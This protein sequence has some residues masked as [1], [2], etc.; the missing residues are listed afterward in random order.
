MP[1]K[2][3]TK[4]E[5]AKHTAAAYKSTPVKQDVTTTNKYDKSTTKSLADAVP[6]LSR[7]KFADFYFR[8]M[9][10]LNY[11]DITE[12]WLD[13]PAW[14]PPPLQRW[15]T[16]KYDYEDII[17]PPQKNINI[18][19]AA[20]TC[21]VPDTLT[22]LIRNTSFGEL[23]TAWQNIM[24]Y[25]R[26]NTRAERR[27]RKAN[28]WRMRMK[29]GEP[30]AIFHEK[31][32]REAN[33]I[34]AM[35]NQ[36]VISNNDMTD[37][38]IEGVLAEHKSEF[39][40]IVTIVDEEGGDLTFDETVQRL[41][42]I[43]TTL[44]LQQARQPIK[45]G[46]NVNAAEDRWA[47]KGLHKPA[48]NTCWRWEK[49]GAC[50]YQGCRYQHDPKTKGVGRITK[51]PASRGNGHH[52]LR[53][54]PAKTYCK[55][56]YKRS[57]RIFTNHSDSDCGFRDRVPGA[58]PNKAHN[59]T[60]E[61]QSAAL[62]EMQKDLA[63][64]KSKLLE[65]A[66]AKESANLGL[67]T[68]DDDGADDEDAEF[69]NFCGDAPEKSHEHVGVTATRHTSMD[70]TAST[71]CEGITETLPYAGLF[72]FVDDDCVPLDCDL[73]NE[74]TCRGVNAD[75]PRTP[76]QPEGH[77]AGDVPY[78]RRGAEMEMR[79]NR[80]SQFFTLLA[81]IMSYGGHFAGEILRRIWNIPRNLI[82]GNFRSDWRI[83]SFTLLCIALCVTAEPASD[84]NITSQVLTPHTIH[85]IPPPPEHHR[86]PNMY[87]HTSPLHR[88]TKHYSLTFRTRMAT[89]NPTNNNW[90]VDSG[91]TTHICTDASAFIPGTLEA[92]SVEITLADGGSI[93]AT[94][95]GTVKLASYIG[96]EMRMTTLHDVLLV[97]TA[98]Y[99]L[100][101]VPKLDDAGY[102][103][104]M[105][106]GTVRIGTGGKAYLF[107]DKHRGRRLYMLD[108]HTNTVQS[109]SANSAFIANSYTTGLN[110]FD[111]WHRRLGHCSERYIKK[112]C[113]KIP[114][115]QKLSFC[116]A[117]KTA[118]LKKQPFTKRPNPY[119]TE[120]MENLDKVVSD[121]SGK[122]PT[123]AL[124]THKRYFGLIV[125][126][127]SR[128]TWV[129]TLRNKSDFM[130]E[131]QDWV[132]YV[133]NQTGKY[134]KVFHT[135]GGG[136]F[137]N[138]ELETYCKQLGIEF[139][140]TTPHNP[141]QNAYAERKIG[142]IKNSAK[143][144]MAQAG[145]TPGYWE[146]A[147]K[148]AVHIA[149]RTPHKHLKYKTP[150]ELWT[151]KKADPR[152][153]QHLRAFGCEA[154]TH[155]PEANRKSMGDKGRKGVFV[156]MGDKEQGYLVY[157]FHTRRV[158]TSR[159]V[160]FNETCFPLAEAAK[161]AEL[162][163][164]EKSNSTNSTK[165]TSTTSASPSSAEP[166]ATAQRTSARG[167]VPSGQALRNL[168]N[169]LDAELEDINT[170]DI[171]MVHAAVT[172]SGVPQTRKAAMASK[173]A[174]EWK[175]AE[176]TELNAL[177]ENNTWN[178][179][180]LPKGV[181]PISCRWVYDLKRNEDN[182]IARYK[183]RLVAKGFQQVEGVNY[184]ETFA[185]VAQMKSFRVIMALATTLNLK[186][187]QLDVKNAFLNGDLEEDIYMQPPPGIILPEGKILKLQKSLYGLK[188][189]GRT[190]SLAL[191]DAL[192][193][194]GFKQLYSDA[195][196][197]THPD[198]Q[199]ILS[200]H[201]DDILIATNDERMRTHVITAL[202]KHF[203][204]KDEGNCSFYLGMH[205]SRKTNTTTIHQ[206]AYISRMVESFRMT[207]AT[208]APTPADCNIVHSKLNCRDST[209]TNT[210]QAQFS[211]IPYRSLIGALLYAG[212]GTR[213]D[214]SQ[215]V[216]TLA[217]FCANFG[218]T[219]WTAAKRI[220]RYLKGTLQR[221]IT[222]Y[223]EG[224]VCIRAFS[225]SDWA[226]DVDTRRSRTGIVVFI[227]SGPVIWQSRAQRTVALS[228][229]E[230][231]YM[232]LTEAIKEIM[233][234]RQF[235]GELDIPFNADIPLYIDN[236]AAIAL[237]KN[238]VHHAR[239]KHIDIRYKFIREIIETRLVTPVYV[240]TGENIA[241]LFTKAT[242]TATFRKLVDKLVSEA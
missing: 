225:D 126:V 66:E 201:V 239:S 77:A 183:A 140:T 152:L 34:N 106:G 210:Q 138:G 156:G 227:A 7:D 163:K 41:T 193:S 69:W 26:S 86:A 88:T 76:S 1:R 115:H 189:A 107:G 94:R 119:H 199:F 223:R 49:T 114:I 155:V 229:C 136:E 184:N 131:F 124:H 95:K 38:L 179:V 240:P 53:P 206:N 113:P 104:V 2:P 182:T 147:I 132:A 161:A 52:N 50:N 37:V 208:P 89:S 230:A 146:Y 100:V 29:R 169:V 71:A 9:Q 135:D 139:T 93:H 238:P 48:D 142:V 61:K 31:V 121:L 43:G 145:M 92:C 58:E 187:T 70:E 168:A 165:T 35:H 127:H 64:L 200:V 39:S 204:I 101:S 174:P 197:Y 202:Q 137:V 65:R 195:C 215:A 67:H 222:Y 117:C 164:A 20:L 10:L 96:N 72:E 87:M 221:G 151:G 108:A 214:I 231:E 211:S 166:A 141:N 59:D 217:C 18:A 55:I 207:D 25:F 170:H 226:G 83:V 42:S 203:K 19:Y 12:E 81:V 134:P 175:N 220:L 181:K 99:N 98:P 116:P 188:Q 3:T 13:P 36:I 123:E 234:L 105:E 109:H 235:L 120:T 198:T 162:R 73:K 16:D 122:M 112:V 90:M 128:Y 62:A 91:A 21:K 154:W 110:D 194:L 157:D 17:Q 63:E 103:T 209:L 4:E 150:H 237:A 216:T 15:T 159:D 130:Q 78:E 46:E 111:L 232:A 47:M 24:R 236:K 97:P 191:R 27:K 212:L 133:H 57:G 177:N 75:V 167:W 79:T 56:C 158:I 74:D 68:G 213:P 144:M 82:N 185:G 45:T 190:W 173:Q 51:P 102:R 180:D 176:Q 85:T 23:R 178:V 224:H 205:V 40:T 241:D 60:E 160:E 143:A 84:L 6:M 192:L 148:Y 233:W 171:E 153:V 54:D 5:E 172:H 118:K 149:N 196:V 218:M 11:L 186:T 242:T 22:G 129:V 33:E 8:M 14:I 44:D 28:F 219:Q 228:S 30:F 32:L 125:D 80:I